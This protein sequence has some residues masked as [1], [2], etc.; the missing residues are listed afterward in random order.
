MNLHLSVHLSVIRFTSIV[1]ST[2]IVMLLGD[3]SN[4]MAQYSVECAT[5]NGWFLI[6]RDFYQKQTEAHTQ[7][8][9]GS[10]TT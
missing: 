9:L 4:N 1:N 7:T 8:Q 10:P 3:N 2:I 5:V 6:Y